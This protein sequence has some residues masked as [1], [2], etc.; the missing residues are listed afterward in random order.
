MVR[1]LAFCAAPAVLLALGGC[2]TIDGSSTQAIS[3]L[4][5]DAN[6]KP[7]NGMRCRVGNGAADYF[8]NSPL[9]DVQIRRSASDLQ[10]ECRS[11]KQVASATAFARGSSIS[12][13]VLLPGGGAAAL[14]DRLSGYAYAYPR[15]IQLRVGEHMLFDVS[16]P[17]RGSGEETADALMR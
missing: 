9:L 6:G 16:A 15:T 14:I 8:G 17:A 13:L 1:R 4:T 2:A 3:I 7:V 11:G 12:G 10:I 5:I